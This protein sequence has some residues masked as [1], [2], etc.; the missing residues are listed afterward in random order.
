MPSH[1]KW[2]GKLDTTVREV[3]YH[4]SR[5]ANYILQHRRDPDFPWSLKAP[6]DVLE[7]ICPSPK[8]LVVPSPSFSKTANP[9]K[10][11]RMQARLVGADDSLG[12]Q[13]VK[14][15][16]GATNL[17]M[18]CEVCGLYVQQITDQASFN[19]LMQHP[20][21]GQGEPLPQWGIHESHS[22]INM[23]VQWSCKKCG[24]LQRPHQAAGAKNLQKPCD[25]RAPVSQLGKL[26]QRA[27]HQSLSSS[28]PAIPVQK[29]AVPF[30][31]KRCEQPTGDKGIKQSVLQFGGPSVVSQPKTKAQAKAKQKQ[32]KLSFAPVSRTNSPLQ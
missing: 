32:S 31:T 8:A 14:G 9:N 3:C 27:N 22:M 6:T 11:Q 19:R 21:A 5:K 15:A 4:L 1:K 10:K 30:G 2:L 12:H 17:T 23:G 18:K 29:V 20:C 25:G 26:A 28:A 24:R 16:E 7:S 13:W